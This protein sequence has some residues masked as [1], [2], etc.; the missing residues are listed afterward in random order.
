M[1]G[2]CAIMSRRSGCGD[3]LTEVMKDERG[4]EGG[5]G[6]GMTEI[7]CMER[8]STTDTLVEA[9]YARRPVGLRSAAPP[10]WREGGDGRIKSHDSLVDRR[11]LEDDDIAFCIYIYIYINESM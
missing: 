6:I 4:E 2:S 9:A 5:G 7:S 1:D 8:E 11:L 3:H 10:L